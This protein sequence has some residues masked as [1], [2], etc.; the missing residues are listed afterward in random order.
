MKNYRILPKDII[1]KEIDG[2][3]HYFVGDRHYSSVTHILD[4]AGPKEYGLINFFKT[5]SP[6]EIEA[7]KNQTAEFG[8]VVHDAI[9]KLLFGVELKMSDYT[10]EH[11][12]LLVQ[13]SDWFKTVRPTQYLPEQVVVWDGALSDD[14][15]QPENDERTTEER[16]NDEPDADRFAGTLDFL[17]EI[18]AGNLVKVPNCFSSKAAQ[19]RF[20]EK[21]PADKKLLCL[22][23]F[24]TTSGIYF[25]HKLQLGAYKLAAEQMFGRPIDVCAVLRLGTRHKAGYEF[26]LVNGDEFG[27][28]FMNVMDTYKMLNGGKLPDPPK[29]E[30]YPETIQL[31]EADVKEAA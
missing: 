18:E 2:S 24:K 4:V 14:M 31:V 25:S 23:D 28:T 29:I 13:F 15:P 7:I 9:E 30:V 27:N 1:R 5:N 16:L 20:L 17:G 22:I 12:K 19:D 10:D 26:K 8:T 3:H 11:K 21:Y 6:S